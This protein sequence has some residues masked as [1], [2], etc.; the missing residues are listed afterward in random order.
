MAGYK[1][2]HP[3]STPLTIMIPTE[4]RVQGVPQKSLKEGDLFFGGVRSFSSQE[5]DS[6]GV[7]SPER[8]LVIDTWYRPDIK[9][10]NKIRL[11]P[12]GELYDII[13]E[14]EDIGFRHQFLQIRCR[15]AGGKA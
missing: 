8:T 10:N 11:E 14:P 5:R 6:N 4:E 13:G 7:I 3:F 15:R 12:G 9:A 1:P 2:F